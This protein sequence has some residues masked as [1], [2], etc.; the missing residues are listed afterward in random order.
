MTNTSARKIYVGHSRCK[1]QDLSPHPVQHLVLSSAMCSNHFGGLPR[2]QENNR[3]HQSLSRC[4]PL[5]FEKR[6]VLELRL[7]SLSGRQE[8][9]KKY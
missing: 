2:L 9:K 7:V 5:S 1:G 4:G 8:R 6:V 3:R